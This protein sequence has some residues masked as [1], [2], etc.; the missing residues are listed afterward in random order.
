MRINDITI[1][2]LKEYAHV[3]HNEDDSLFENILLASKAYVQSY[4]GLSVDSMNEKE[5][6]TMVVYVIAM[7]LYDNR[8]FIVDTDKVNFVINSIL[9]MYSVN[10][11]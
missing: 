4:T 7:E 6:L 10:L 3:Y 8:T 11:L 2:D 9:N 1:S 5:D